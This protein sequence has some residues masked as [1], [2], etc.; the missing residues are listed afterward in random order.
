MRFGL[1]WGSLAIALSSSVM[2]SMFCVSPG[3][4]TDSQATADWLSRMSKNQNY[5]SSFPLGLV[6]PFSSCWSHPSTWTPHCPAPHGSMVPTRPASKCPFMPTCYP[7]QG[8]PQAPAPWVIPE[9]PHNPSSPSSLHQGPA[10][11]S[12]L[13]GNSWRAGPVLCISAFPLTQGIHQ[14]LHLPV[15]TR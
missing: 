3:N 13:Q 9:A 5:Q 12:F 7:S 11:A 10:L 2:S 4:R 1:R 8:L 14:I 6:N 15:S